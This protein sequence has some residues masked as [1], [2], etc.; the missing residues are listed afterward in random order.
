MQVEKR[1]WNL[2]LCFEPL[3]EPF[4]LLHLHHTSLSKPS[5]SIL[6]NG[7]DVLIDL[8]TGEARRVRDEATEEDVIEFED[9][10]LSLEVTSEHTVVCLE[11]KFSY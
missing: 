11:V 9:A 6:D 10:E 1:D 7:K 3:L 8:Q 2:F 5:R 4:P